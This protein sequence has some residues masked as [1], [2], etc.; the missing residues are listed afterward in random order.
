MSKSSWS[1][2]R[3]LRSVLPA[4]AG[5]S[6][7]PV[8]VEE[9]TVPLL[10][11]HLDAHSSTPSAHDDDTNARQSFEVAPQ[12]EIDNRG[13]EF[14]DDVSIRLWTKAYN[15][16][17]R[18]NPEL[19]MTFEE[20]LWQQIRVGNAV[21]SPQPAAAMAWSGICAIIPILTRPWQQEQAMIEGLNH[22]FSS[23]DWYMDLANCVV[24]DPWE[25]NPQLSKLKVGLK[26]RIVRV[27]E[28]MLQYQMESVAHCYEKHPIIRGV[29]TILGSNDWASRTKEMQDRESRLKK[30]LA[31]YSSRQGN[32]ISSS[33]ARTAETT[34]DHLRQHF[35]QNKLSERATVI[36]R[37]KTTCYEQFMEANPPRVPGT[38]EWLRYRDSFTDWNYQHFGLLLISAGPGCGKSV[39]AR[40]LVQDVLPYGDPAAT[41][42]YFFF[43][44]STEQR[45]LPNALCAII[46][47]ILFQLNDL[48]DH[49]MDEIQYHGLELLSDLG[50]LWRVFE[51]AV[52]HQSKRQIICV[53]DALDECDE[54]ERQKF[55]Q[56][57][58]KFFSRRAVYPPKVKFLI[59]TREDPE[60]LQEFR[61][62]EST[63]TI[64]LSEESRMKEVN[65]RGNVERMRGVDLLPEINLVVDHRLGQLSAN[66]VL[67]QGVLLLIRNAL[68]EPSSEPRTYLWVSRV[69]DILDQNFDNTPGKWEKLARHTPKTVFQAYEGMLRGMAEEEVKRVTRLFHLIIAAVKPLTVH[70]MNVALHVRD[71]ELAYSE[72]DLALP[73]DQ[74]FQ[75]WMAST[76]GGFIT[77][78]NGRV[79]FTHRTAN[80]F[81]LKPDDGF[82]LA[83]EHP[84]WEGSV[85]MSQAHRTMAESCIA[86]LSLG[87]FTTSKF[88]RVTQVF[89]KGLREA[90]EKLWS[91]E[92]Y[93]EELLDHAY[94]NCKQFVENHS[95]SSYSLYALQHWVSHF[96]SAQEFV[97]HVLVRDIDL[98]LD[99]AYL[100]LFDDTLPITRPWLVMAAQVLEEDCGYRLTE[101][102]K[103]SGVVR[104]HGS[105][106]RASLA[107]LFGHWRLTERFLE[108]DMPDIEVDMSME[109]SL[110]DLVI[111]PPSTKHQP[112]FF[113]AA[114][115]H[116]NCLD[117]ILT[118]LDL[119]DGL[120]RDQLWRTPLHQ[121]ARLGRYECL[122]SLANR[123]D[124][125]EKDTH[126]WNA[127]DYLI[128]RINGVQDLEA[129]R[130]IMR[131]L[132]QARAERPDDP[133]GRRVSLLSLAAKSPNETF[134][135]KWHRPE[136]VE[137]IV[138]SR[139]FQVAYEG[140]LIK[141]LVDQGEDVNRPELTGLTP[142]HF[143]STR[144]YFWNVM[145][146][147]Y[148]GAEA[149]AV[150][151]LDRTPL[152]FACSLTAP[153][154][155]AIVSALLKGGAS[156]NGR[157]TNGETPF[158][159]SVLRPD[160][161]GDS[162][163]EL[164]LAHGA[165]PYQR[166]P[167]GGTP[168]D[169]A[170][171]Y[172]T[173]VPT[174]RNPTIT[175]LLTR[176]PIGLADNEF[177]NL[178][179]D[180]FH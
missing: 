116:S 175:R 173:T 180:K 69:L 40:Y 90:Q 14:V 157:D 51:K 43:K 83:Q 99:A 50:S 155:I 7:R 19:V 120:V 58:R 67:D 101:F 109:T 45:S 56:L 82:P 5:A 1:F 87:A 28:A 54:V 94:G 178:L 77:E 91:K 29:K 126:D 92:L 27:Y 9:A 75:K 115:G 144:G 105:V 52:S 57:L 150:D 110:D 103:Q 102:D 3:A 16:M 98:D 100:K 167:D 140:S 37:F 48:V 107:S 8:Q 42:A 128:H 13:L 179:D 96:D 139:L 6:D 10:G 156:P 59:T 36:G 66:K 142:L 176:T 63:Y 134:L 118:R 47:R 124:I 97:D 129:S 72:D 23:M 132:V 169:R 149:S 20:V 147:L 11:E 131:T 172:I 76:C 31:Q 137:D 112:V 25:G 174:L 145:F 46:H 44:N 151:E 12:K 55:N 53:L 93:P 74:N 153:K 159:L 95:L 22:V 18:S 168:L 123:F 71:R 122:E 33:I 70:E 104:C 49:C 138:D 84:T 21:L 88:T 64:S 135:E 80:E 160:D 119:S 38:C 113:A 73:S 117:Y 125:A 65:I 127:F 143:A 4:P 111:D 165:Y 41:V 136:L 62:F 2:K 166:L 39:L 133:N 148:A 26:G 171:W 152:H 32:D 60:V 85:T 86:Y 108:E 17:R 161:L 61:G 89:N 141:F 170:R 35:G 121:A 158:G 106:R 15:S 114:T 30:E 162:L 177:H 146:L 130:N 163:V 164:M 24:S 68:E 81:L 34:L 79:M 154:S 78:F